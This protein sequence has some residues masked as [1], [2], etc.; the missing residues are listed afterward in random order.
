MPLVMPVLVP[1]AGCL[2]LVP[3][4]PL[5]LS[6]LLSPRSLVRMTPQEVA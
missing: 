4:V 5:V 6:L 1:L 3:L 2:L